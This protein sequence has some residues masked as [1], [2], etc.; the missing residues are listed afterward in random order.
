MSET[1][2]SQDILIELK[3]QKANPKPGKLFINGEFVDAL[4]GKTF[5]TI[6]PAT[7][8]VI[9]PIAEGDAAD[10]DRAVKAAAAV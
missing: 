2:T 8:E 1:M 9:V 5:D 4:S 10:V 6:N 3:P 7:G